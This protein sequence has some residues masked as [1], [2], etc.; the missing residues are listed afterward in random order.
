MQLAL[1]DALARVRDGA[2][3]SEPARARVSRPPPGRARRRRSPSRPA[4]RST[5][6]RSTATGW[7]SRSSSRTTWASARGSS[8]PAPG[9]RSRTAGRAS[10]SRARSSRVAARTTRSSRGC[11]C[12]TARLRGP[13][14]VMGGFIQ[15]QAHLQLVSGARGRRARPSGGARAS[16]VQG[17][18][19]RREARGGALGARGRPR[20][21]RLSR[22]CCETNAGYFGGGQAIL[23]SGDALVGGSDPRK[24][25]YAGGC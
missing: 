22:R 13:F 3:V 12:A 11:S 18:R 25:G 2:D 1:E 15:A 6:A 14:G 24:D 23:V 19:G 20:R 17:G 7:R 4:A 16:A 10:P 5:S 9:S 8:R 21:R